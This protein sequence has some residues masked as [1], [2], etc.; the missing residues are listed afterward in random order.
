MSSPDSTFSSGSPVLFAMSAT[1][2]SGRWSARGPPYS[3]FARS[4]SSRTTM[5]PAA[6]E[7]TIALTTIAS[8]RLER[9]CED[10]AIVSR[11]AASSRAEPNRSPGSFFRHLLTIAASDPETREG[12]AGAA[13]AMTACPVSSTVARSNGGAPESI[14]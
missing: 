9:A 5:A 3:F 11:P 8:R 14:S 12:S 2:T 10:C 13:S 7:N 1:A 6:A 4:G